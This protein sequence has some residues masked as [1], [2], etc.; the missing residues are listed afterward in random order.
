MWKKSFFSLQYA[1]S[2][3]QTERQDSPREDSSGEGL[4]HRMHGIWTTFINR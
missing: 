4:E 1:D 2:N 3:A